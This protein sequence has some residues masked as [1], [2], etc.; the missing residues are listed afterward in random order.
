[1]PD[2]SPNAPLKL[3]IA[4]RDDPIEYDGTPKISITGDGGAKLSFD[5]R[6]HLL[7]WAKTDRAKVT[8]KINGND[9][10]NGNVVA[11]SSKEY[12]SPGGPLF[13]YSA[14]GYYDHLHRNPI[15]VIADG[16]IAGILDLLAE[17]SGAADFIRSIVFRT[18]EI[19]DQQLLD[20]VPIKEIKRKNIPIYGKFF[21]EAIMLI[22]GDL[23]RW[24][25][26]PGTRDLVIYN[27]EQLIK[28]P[29]LNLATIQ[30]GCGADWQIVDI[31]FNYDESN[32]SRVIA[33]KDAESL[34]YQGNIVNRVIKS[35]IPLFGVDTQQF[36]LK[37]KTNKLI[38][39]R[40]QGEAPSSPSTHDFH[41][42]D[43]T[44]LI[45]KSTYGDIIALPAYVYFPPNP[46]ELIRFS[47]YLIARR[48]DTT[49]FHDEYFDVD[50]TDEL[51]FFNFTVDETIRGKINMDVF[52]N[53]SALPLTI[54]IRYQYFRPDYNSFLP[55]H[56]EFQMGTTNLELKLNDNVIFAQT[57][58]PGDVAGNGLDA[59]QFLD[60]SNLNLS[61]EVIVSCRIWGD[62]NWANNGLNYITPYYRLSA[63]LSTAGFFDPNFGP[64]RGGFP[65][66]YP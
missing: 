21:D 23:A 65:E 41:H 42:L 30:N 34:K 46:N 64:S 33:A 2:S 15:N 59:N 9:W 63:V 4:H 20:F 57:Y 27:K 8:A 22:L 5:H 50:I 62:F 40:L 58:G 35:V 28:R 39:F 6:G 48:L 55:D 43:G 29:A 3:F 1:M 10:F 66:L 11:R 51:Q 25:F 17:E 37:D 7:P 47:A 54:A 36:P 52:G 18:G 13:S 24:Y 44:E 49:M 38:S 14:N 53:I 12:G 31:D 16:T 19:Y 32:I 61:G 56:P 60:I 45:L 26:H